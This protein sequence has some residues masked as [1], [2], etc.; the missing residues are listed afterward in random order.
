MSSE[1]SE[2]ETLR[3][4]GGSARE[5]AEDLSGFAQSE[6]VLSA[7]REEFVA[8][9]LKR[10]VG[11]YEGAVA[12]SAET[13]DELLAELDRTGVPRRHTAVRFIDNDERALIL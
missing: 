4:L 9:Y 2:I 6:N 13:L 3:Q 1:V 12:A 10:W 5:I 8:K 11:V 7:R